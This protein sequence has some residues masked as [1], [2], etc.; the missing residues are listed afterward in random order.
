MMNIKKIIQIVHYVIAKYKYRINYTK[1]IKLLYLADRQALAE[2]GT[3]ITGDTYYAMANGPVLSTLYDLIRGKGSDDMKIMWNSVFAK[4]GYDIY[5]LSEN[6]S[7][8]ELSEYEEKVLD[9]IDE[10][11][12][13]MTYTKMIN[14]VHNKEICPEWNKP[15]NGA[16]LIKPE[17]ILLFSGWSDEDIDIW[18]EENQIF[19][20]EEKILN[21][22]ES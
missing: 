15:V 1:L 18:K 8:G 6:I 16:K 20:E 7:Y 14:L 19:E 21:G 17:S 12:H 22:L 4:D 13:N 11:Y 9:D 3:S 2:T 5:A 10:K